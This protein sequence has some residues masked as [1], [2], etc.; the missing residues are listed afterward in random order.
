[1]LKKV[2]THESLFSPPP[3]ALC[4]SLLPLSLP[5]NPLTPAAQSVTNAKLEVWVGMPLEAMAM[6][7]SMPRNWAWADWM[8]PPN[9][10]PSNIH[11]VGEDQL[12]S[13]TPLE[14]CGPD[15]TWGGSLGVPH[16][17]LLRY[18]QAVQEDPPQLHIRRAFSSHFPPPHS[19]PHP[20]ITSSPPHPLL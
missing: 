8:T 15:L 11:G 12:P 10:L 18:S 13:A 7:W 16:S 9:T 5:N 3:P 4:S 2:R 14:A 19:L 6:A 20:K 1:M 17:L